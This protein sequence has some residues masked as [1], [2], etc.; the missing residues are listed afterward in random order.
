[1][2]QQRKLREAV[3]G[4]LELKKNAYQRPRAN[5]PTTGCEMNP[6]EARL[7]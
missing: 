2:R 5:A 3:V 6:R 4:V 1:M 7:S